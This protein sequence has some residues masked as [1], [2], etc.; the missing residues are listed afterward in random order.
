M[1]SAKKSDENKPDLSLLPR[2]AKEEVAK[3]F[4]FGAEK[5]G[6][7]NYL[8]GMDWTRL[9][10]AADRHMTKWND[11]ETL[12]EESGLNHLA[13]AICGLMMLLEYKAR[14]LGTDDRYKSGKDS[15]TDS[16]IPY[17]HYIKC[18]DGTVIF[19]EEDVT[20]DY[21]E[22]Y[23]S[24]V[25]NKR[26]GTITMFHPGP[27]LSD[28]EQELIGDALTAYLS[29]NYYIKANHLGDTYPYEFLGIGTSLCKEK[30]AEEE[31]VHVSSTYDYQRKKEAYE[32]ASEEYE[33]AAKKIGI[34]F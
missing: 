8:K 20:K 22:Y 17:R 30:V 18:T 15:H 34:N 33:R 7:Y 2:N 21:S 24:P 6:R 25:F 4:M 11:G 31:P 23:D 12:D 28:D 13:H 14:D 1:S 26:T 5:Y 19:E 9:I 29:G 10:A 27:V 3:V 32:K 16:E